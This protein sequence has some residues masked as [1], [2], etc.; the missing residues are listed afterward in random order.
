MTRR[1]PSFSALAAFEA[2]ARHGRMTRAADELC[3]TH[4]AVSRQIRA[5][6]VQLGARL[7]TGP[8]TALSLTPAGLALAE[9]LTAA[10]ETIRDSLPPDG[11]ARHAAALRLSCN[12]TLAMRWL[13]PRLQDF[14]ASH[15]DVQIE[16]TE[17]YAPVDFATGE[18][19][20][21]LRLTYAEA[22]PGQVVTDIMPHDFGPVAAPGTG[23]VFAQPRLSSRTHPPAWEE[24]AEA[25]NTRLPPATVTREF[26]HMFYMLE[27]AAAGLG[28]AI[29]SWP[30]V[31][32]DIATHRLVAPHGF[33]PGKGRIALFAPKRDPHPGVAPLRAWL[34]AQA[35]AMPS[36]YVS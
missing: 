26:D 9:G 36:P 28:A 14:V 2:F 27:A 5:L 31:A 29:A 15:A 33:T 35:A 1:L 30:L 23:D 19:D 10:F 3:V 13:I 6:E 21:A 22:V 20:A 11:V 25:W 16:V 34:L 18:Y 32:K 24:W 12:G 8:R 7:V 4:G 17:S